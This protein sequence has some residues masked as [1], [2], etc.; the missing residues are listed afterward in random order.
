MEV[1]FHLLLP[2]AGATVP[3]DRPVL[4]WD[5][6]HTTDATGQGT[7]RQDARP[8]PDAG[9]GFRQTYAPFSLPTR[10]WIMTSDA[11]SGS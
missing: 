5:D 1:G 8:P 6:S 4:A 10:G 11:P 7:R 2:D 9:T 3:Q